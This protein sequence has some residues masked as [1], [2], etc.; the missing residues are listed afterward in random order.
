MSHPYSCHREGYISFWS[1]D[2]VPACTA[3]QQQEEPLC[4]NDI[5]R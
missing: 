3:K 4:V 1:L 2:M 5:F